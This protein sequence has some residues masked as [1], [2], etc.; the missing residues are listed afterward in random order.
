MVQL[1][2]NKTIPVMPHLNIDHVEILY[3]FGTG[4]AVWPK[5][6]DFVYVSQI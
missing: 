5:K 4:A 6:G 3:N 2:Q 1:H